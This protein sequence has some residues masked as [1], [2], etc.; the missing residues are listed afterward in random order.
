MPTVTFEK[1]AFLKA[2]GKKMPDPLLA[3][4]LAMLGTDVQA[5]TETEVSV[6]V[7]PDRPDMLSLPGFA[8]ALRSHL[9]IKKGLAN[10][11]VA[12]GKLVVQV[13]PNLKAIRPVT[14][15]AVVR[16]LKLDDARIKQIIDLQEKLHGTYGRKRKR[17]AMGIYPLDAISFPV[18]YEARA[19]GDITFTPLDFAKPQPAMQILK[20]HPKGK[21]YGQLLFAQRE[22]P[23]FVD[24]D[25]RIM[26]LVPIVNSE[27][28]GKVTIETKNV[29]VEVS[30]HDYDVCHRALLMVCS[31]LA[32]MGG[33]LESVELRYGAKKL[34][35]PDFTPR[36]MKLAA[37]SVN[38]LLGT[39]L[40]QK[41]VCESLEKMGYDAKGTTV[42]VPAYRA[43]ILHEVDLIEDVAI[44]Y[45]YENLRPTMPAIATI[46]AES[47][48]A[49]N[50]RLARNLFVS[51]GYTELKSFCLSSVETQ[52]TKVGQMRRPVEMENPLTAEYSVLRQQLIP[53]LLEALSRNRSNEYPQLLFEIG[54]VWT[55]DEE[56]R[57]AFV[58]CGEKAGFTEAKAT[59][60]AALRLVG[61]ELALKPYEEKLFISGRAA[62]LP[63]GFFGEVHPQ[64]LERF[65]IPFGVAAGEL[66]IKEILE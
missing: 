16:K 7:F 37:A 42:K 32:D 44:G 59:I 60:E 45:G 26:S 10:Y 38:E 19:P 43:D 31:A 39:T 8:R 41:Q 5:I 14:A 49:R 27:H 47:P 46:A 56:Q 57:I 25:E 50:E 17:V 6:E 53:G 66:R 36:T 15:C 51:L 2:V 35:S 11:P 1:Q 29:F 4:K 28:T 21:E 54:P 23:V 48:T 24:N 64:V 34:R 12:K 22:F 58:I 13:D 61:K 40:S 3:E 65:D 55:P 30:G 62:V 20:D 18:R 63:G 9:G 52:V 33:A